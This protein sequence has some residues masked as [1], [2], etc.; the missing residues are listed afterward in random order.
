M[1]TLRLAELAQVLDARLIGEDGAITAVS[2]D[3]RTLGAGALFVALRGERFDAHDF[4][5]QAV[6]TGAIEAQ[7]RYQPM[8][9][10]QWQ[11]RRSSREEGFMLLRMKIAA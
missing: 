11:I 3:T 8:T 9:F 6:V 10:V 7:F 4:C 1:M 2:T 5:E